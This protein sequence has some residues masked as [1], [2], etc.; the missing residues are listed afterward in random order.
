MSEGTARHRTGK[1]KKVTCRVC[2]EELNFQSYSDHLKARHPDKNPNNHR[3][4][5]QRTLFGTPAA[6]AP[7]A[8][9]P[10]PPPAPAKRRKTAEED[11]QDD[12]E[13]RDWL[14]GEE[15]DNMI[16]EVEIVDTFE[17]LPE[18]EGED[19]EMLLDE[20]AED[21]GGLA[22]ASLDEEDGGDKEEAKETIDIEQV[23]H[24]L[25]TILAKIECKVDTSA[26]R[27]E[28]EIL[29]LSLTVVEKRLAVNKD[30]KNLVTK[31]EDLKMTESREREVDMKGIDEDAVIKLQDGA[32]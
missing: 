9:P 2:R 10:A 20:E 5:H 15:E 13:D 11:N 4:Y 19:E 18:A 29:N 30:V 32:P 25:E 6:P 21:T 12:S 3:D 26:C 1:L 22:E 8:E 24:K 17:E 27:S 23:N 14:G 31:L 7:L 28:S 16:E